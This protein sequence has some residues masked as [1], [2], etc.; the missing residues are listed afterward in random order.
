MAAEPPILAAEPPILASHSPHDFA[1]RIHSPLSKF[2]PRTR[3]IPPATQASVRLTV[4]VDCIQIRFF[5]LGISL[6]CY[7]SPVL[8]GSYSACMGYLMK[9]PGGFKDVYRYV[10]TALII[11][12][13]KVRILGKGV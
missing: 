5:Q 7:C 3:T 13:N 10:K 2:L 9:F 1:A 8:A 12:E 6:V 4:V 11:R